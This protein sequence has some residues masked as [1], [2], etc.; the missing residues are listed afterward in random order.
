MASQP[1][2]LYNLKGD[3][4]AASYGKKQYIITKFDGDLNI[5]STYLVSHNDC[6]CP[7]GVRDTCRHRQML[8]LML[9]RIN[10]AWFYCF[11]D[12]QWYDPTGEAEP[13][14]VCNYEVMKDGSTVQNIGAP[15]PD[16]SND[17]T[18]YRGCP[19]CHHTWGHKPECP[20][21]VHEFIDRV[22]PAAEPAKLRRLR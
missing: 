19:I 15:A 9:D 4:A 12:K 7:A 21:Y 10:S 13:K 20:H 16:L 22:Y 5:E 2:T 3:S 8:P 18:P 14:L 11:D 6:T 1:L 17:D